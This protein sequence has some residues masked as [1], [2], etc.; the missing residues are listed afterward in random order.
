MVDWAYR[1]GPDSAP[2]PLKAIMGRGAQG[3]GRRRRGCH[4][5]SRLVE[6]RWRA[7]IAAVYHSCSHVAS[8]PRC[9]PPCRSGSPGGPQLHL[10]SLRSPT[11]PRSPG[12]LVVGAHFTTP[13]IASSSWLSRRMPVA[14]RLSARWSNRGALLCPLNLWKANRTCSGDC[15]TRR[16]TMRD[17]EQ[18]RAHGK[19]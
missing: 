13:H 8:L 10:P 12:K 19:R 1:D 11:G 4:D 16:A 7:V 3:Q 18:P 6:Q 14:A 17:G 5:A 15:P 2:R 9:L